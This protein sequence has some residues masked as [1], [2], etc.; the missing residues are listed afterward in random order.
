MAKSSVNRDHVQWLQVRVACVV[1]SSRTLA[2]NSG[3]SL[4]L[5]RWPAYWV[6]TDLGRDANELSSAVECAA[7]EELLEY[8]L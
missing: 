3:P 5:G 8:A 7:C 1:E 6:Q 4:R 2:I